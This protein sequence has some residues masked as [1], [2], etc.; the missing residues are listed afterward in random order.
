MII[1]YSIILQ[2][3]TPNNIEKHKIFND[4]TYTKNQKDKHHHKRK[5]AL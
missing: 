4:M 3:L 5:L 2:L 1:K